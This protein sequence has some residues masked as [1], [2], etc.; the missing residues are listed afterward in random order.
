MKEN[1]VE[2]KNNKYRY[3]Y[4]D[5][6]TVYMGPV[7]DGPLLSEEDF[8]AAMA[9][10]RTPMTDEEWSDLV[11]TIEDYQ[12]RVK[13]YEKKITKKERE[14]MVIDRELTDLRDAKMKEETVLYQVYYKKIIDR[15]QHPAH[16]KNPIKPFK[17]PDLRTGVIAR[18]AIAVFHGGAEF[19]P[20]TLEVWSKGYYEY[21]GG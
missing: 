21:T 14:R 20:D 2:I 11:T 10:M 15:Y 17:V 12:G 16:W 4:K 9:E 3:R 7:G 1:I 18:H 8:F 6:E 13:G 5:G 19:N